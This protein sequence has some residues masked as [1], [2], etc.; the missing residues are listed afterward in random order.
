MISLFTIVPDV[1]SVISTKSIK[2]EFGAG[3]TYL[4]RTNKITEAKILQQYK[5]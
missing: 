2:L 1:Q 4:I 3:V 5:K